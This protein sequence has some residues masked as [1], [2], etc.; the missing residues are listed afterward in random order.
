[1]GDNNHIKIINPH[2]SEIQKDHFHHLGFDT[3]SQSLKQEYGNIKFVCIS[4]SSSR[5]LKFAKFIQ[6]ILNINEQDE[7]KDRCLTDRYAMYKIGPVLAV[8]H[9]MGVPSATILIH[10]LLKLLHYA[11]A[12][13][14]T[15][16][17]MGTSGGLGL[18]P[19]T[20]VVTKQAVDGLLRPYH[21][22]IVL[23]KIVEYATDIGSDLSDELASYSDENEFH[24][25]VEQGNTMCC[26]D[27]YEGQ[28]RLDGAF[29]DYSQKEKLEFLNKAHANEVRNIEMESLVVASLCRRAGVKAAIVCVVLVDR[30]KDDQVLLTKEELDEFQTRP[31]RLVAHYIK[32]HV[33]K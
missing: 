13:D 20:V 24:F 11:G 15:F 7:L 25:N 30:L 26:D 8:S 29:C 19:G 23:G 4:G 1:M 5:V 18:T 10:E 2:L 17:R 6:T 21:R 33:P 14:V 9:G 31:W 12:S 16:F 3:G 27:F 28:G 32:K 22:Q